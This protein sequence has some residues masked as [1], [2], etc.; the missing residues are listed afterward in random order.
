MAND[1]DLL[2]SSPDP[3]GIS[4]ESVKAS[5]PSMDWSG[6]KLTPRK[7]LIETSNNVRL[8]KFYLTTPSA[9]RSRGSSPV[10]V[11]AQTE[12]P[13][14]P[15][16]I[17][18]T[19]E[20]ERDD[21]DQDAST[22]HSNI[23]KCANERTTTTRVPLKDA[24][25]A[26][27]NS[28]RKVR[29]RPRKSLDSPAKR[30]GTPKPKASGRHK[31][32]SPSLAK[33]ANPTPPK[34]SRGRP[35]KSLESASEGSTSQAGN[36]VS[37]T[38]GLAKD[39][40]AGS[41]VTEKSCPRSKGGR[42]APTPI[43]P[44]AGSDSG[45]LEAKERIDSCPN[46]QF[47]GKGFLK[48]SNLK[49]KYS[50]P[51]SEGTEY[52]SE[53]PS[54][55]R[56]VLSSSTESPFDK[57]TNHIPS[58]KIAFDNQ[59][60]EQYGD[61]A[62]IVNEEMERENPDINNTDDPINEHQ[63]YDSILDGE[64]FSMVSLSSLPCAKLFPGYLVD[65]NHLCINKP[66]SDSL[67]D[68]H[69][70][71]IESSMTSV[72]PSLNHHIDERHTPLAE[73]STTSVP[74]SLKP[75]NVRNSPR[76][77]EKVTAGTPKLVR[78]VRA[79]IALQG[80]LSPENAS[81][82]YY[83][84][85]KID[86]SSA[87]SP[88][89]RLDHLFSGFGA[90]TGRELRAGLRLGEELARR[91]KDR[92][93]QVPTFSQEDDVFKQEVSAGRSSSFASEETS[94]YSLKVPED[95]RTDLYPL[96]S[97]HQLPSPEVSEIDN[98]ENQMNW[99]ADTLAH[100]KPAELEE[101][102][103]SQREDEFDDA[104]FADDTMMAR[105]AEYQSERNA[106]IEQIDAANAS[107]VIVIDSD[108]DGENDESELETCEQSDIGQAEALSTNIKVESPNGLPSI[109]QNPM[110]KPRRSQLPN[111]WRQ[112]SQKPS[113]TEAGADES[114]HFWQPCRVGKATN[115]DESQNQSPN[116]I[117]NTTVASQAV[118]QEESVG[119]YDEGNLQPE[120]II[121]SSPVNSCLYSTKK[122]TLSAKHRSMLDLDLDESDDDTWAPSTDESYDSE[123]YR[124]EDFTEESVGSQTPQ[125]SPM[126]RDVVENA[127]E[128]KL[129]TPDVPK[130][131]PSPRQAPS[132][133]ISYFTS[134]VPTFRNPSV[135]KAPPLLPNGK[136]YLPIAIS[137]GPLNIYM[138]WTTDHFSALYIHYAAWKEGRA[139]FRFN[140]HSPS[141]KYLNHTAQKGRWRRRVEPGDVA[142][143]DAFLEDLRR[144][145]VSHRSGNR[146]MRIDARLV[147]QMIFVL[148]I[149]GVMNG[150]CEVGKGITGLTLDGEEM[151]RPEL[152]TWFKKSSTEH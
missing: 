31:A 152:E 50:E 115:N 74:P 78:V 9:P 24:D 148:W 3:L 91:Q 84:R 12:N 144:R 93:H 72:P 90:G 20:A 110:V 136:R 76:A 83:K 105:E 139:T 23:Y 19:V 43:K 6:E 98:N 146:E 59:V 133:W 48:A 88:K 66:Q 134:F 68:G 41:R 39:D 107:Q 111:H 116:N 25:D 16:R 117:G 140:P 119:E 145:G 131:Q 114:D 36:L 13:V 138:P 54:S 15:W 106:V 51:Q 89:E 142:I 40:V 58:F 137:E 104:N 11:V 129:T 87:K 22:S 10:K 71:L 86:D 121:F 21:S 82:K 79:G 7:A 147:L 1:H 100:Q 65:R 29:G 62:S 69:T 30:T 5:S 27:L 77:I 45:S 99:K 17:R 26:R 124:A 61:D 35:R 150:E 126:A 53:I 94:E 52:E 125:S 57:N 143:A 102:H 120:S 95:K 135:P 130:H 128:A 149:G 92:P 70:L 109:F 63:E 60:I 49:R 38:Q 42:K 80:V 96:L 18:V 34:K 8:Q 122:V 33:Q 55:L 44:V 37:S 14:S 118:V 108:N 75:A 132:S 141:A 101:E 2:H 73:S 97:N 67:E 4:Q 123:E 81:R 85:S 46:E 151:W 113:F 112:E 28:P 64:G 32:T 56:G 103:E 127:S 47:K